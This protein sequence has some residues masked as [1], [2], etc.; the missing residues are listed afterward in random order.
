VTRFDPNMNQE[1]RDRRLAGWRKAVA[2]VL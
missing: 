2:A 1:D